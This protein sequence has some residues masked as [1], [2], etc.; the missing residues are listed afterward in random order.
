MQEAVS[1]QTNLSSITDN[2]QEFAAQVINMAF[3][4]EA[5]AA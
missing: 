3:A 1:T 4:N 5:I 2:R